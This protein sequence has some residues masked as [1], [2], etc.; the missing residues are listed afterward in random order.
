MN[1]GITWIY[2][3]F[4][5]SVAALLSVIALNYFVDPGYQYHHNVVLQ[6]AEKEIAERFLQ[7]DFGV[8]FRG[9]ERVLAHTLAANAPKQD[10][11]VLGS[12]RALQI[13]RTRGSELAARCPTI[14]NL[15]VF[16]GTIEDIFILLNSL[17]SRKALPSTLFLEL[18]PWMLKWGM[19]KR[20][21]IYREELASFLQQQQFSSRSSTAVSNPF[22]THLQNL[23]NFEYTVL[24]LKALYADPRKALQPQISEQFQEI[25]PFPL[26]QGLD[27]QVRLRDG[28]LVYDSTHITENQTDASY[29][30]AGS[31]KLTGPYFEESLIQEL[32]V[33][34]RSLSEDV[35]L[36]FVLVPYHQSFFR[37][38]NARNFRYVERVEQ[39]IEKLA[40][41]VDAKVF[42][43]YRPEN[44]PCS[45]DEFYDFMHPKAECVDRLFTLNPEN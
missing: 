7:A 26:A 28:S 44:I 41:S 22:L 3:F 24:S 32:T 36:V 16:G 40:H 10:C 17:S 5:C 11:V 33:Y 18:S 35:E 8:L 4:T 31:Y 19:D 42:G 38:E 14:L 27:S 30:D 21:L 1:K 29:F 45:I 12:S 2:T 37:E 34:L 9:N 6:A 20:Y 23:T 43:S 13:S 39:R 25:S 15:S